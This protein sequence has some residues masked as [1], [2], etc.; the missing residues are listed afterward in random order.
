MEQRL[1]SKHRD[2]TECPGGCGYSVSECDCEECE[3]CGALGTSG[4]RESC[5]NYYSRGDE[6]AYDTYEETFGL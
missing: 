4:C 2:L 1:I 6:A 5:P 3:Y